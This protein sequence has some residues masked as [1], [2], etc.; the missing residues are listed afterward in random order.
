MNKVI[1]ITYVRRGEDENY[2]TLTCITIIIIMRVF[3]GFL[4]GSEISLKLVGCSRNIIDYQFC[5]PK[6]IY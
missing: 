1:S 5:N 2:V 6:Y 3:R 4:R